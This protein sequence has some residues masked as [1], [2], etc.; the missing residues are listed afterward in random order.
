MRS[1]C[2]GASEGIVSEVPA[3]KA[4][5]ESPFVD[6][7]LTYEDAAKNCLYIAP[8]EKSVRL[9]QLAIRPLTDALTSSVPVHVRKESSNAP[10]IIIASIL[11]R[12]FTLRRL[13]AI[14]I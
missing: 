13:A 10:C 5:F 12:L 1:F 11:P 4:Q 8:R 14:T 9:S 7:M 6:K 3:R 2:A